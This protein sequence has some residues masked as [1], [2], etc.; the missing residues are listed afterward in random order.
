MSYIAS[1]AFTHPAGAPPVA[2]M[3]LSVACQSKKSDLASRETFCYGVKMVSPC[4]ILFMFQVS[5]GE[6]E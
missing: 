5:L 4:L 1:Q 6:D 2:P 3:D